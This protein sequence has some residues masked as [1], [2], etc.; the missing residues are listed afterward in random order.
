MVTMTLEAK[1]TMVTM[2][3]TS[4][5]IATTTTTTIMEIKYKI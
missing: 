1:P 2:I 5:I 3:A 4:V